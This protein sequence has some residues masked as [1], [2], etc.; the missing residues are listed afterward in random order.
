MNLL[1]PIW[2][3]MRRR[4]GFTLTELLIASTLMALV[5]GG[6]FAI[7][8]S[9]QHF[10]RAVDFRMATDRQINI[11]MNRLIYGMGTRRGL[12]SALSGSAMTYTPSASGWTLRYLAGSGVNSQTN[13]FI[14]STTTSNLTFNPGA[15]LVCENVSLAR[16][17][18]TDPTLTI[19]LRVDRVRGELHARRELGTAI[20]LRN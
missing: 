3:R 20:T 8:L 11:G 7:Y 12:R 1:L 17:L 4:S 2:R 10:W 9:V 14:Y 6:A 19:T 16:V 18:I 5:V 13:F 15:Q